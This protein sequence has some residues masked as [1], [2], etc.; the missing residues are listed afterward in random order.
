VARFQLTRA[1][2]IPSQFRFH[3]GEFVVDGQASVLTP[4]DRIWPGL[5]AKTMAAGMIPLDSLAV[6]MKAASQF[7]NESVAPCISGVDSIV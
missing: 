4:S 6:S 3:A 2:V 7:A 5:T 1:V